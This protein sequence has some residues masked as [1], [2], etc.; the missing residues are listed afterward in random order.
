LASSAGAEVF[1]ALCGSTGS[2]LEAVVHANQ[3]KANK[4]AFRMATLHESRAGLD[5]T[6]RSAAIG[7]TLDDAW[8][9]GKSD[10]RG[11]TWEP[12]AAIQRE[13]AKGRSREFRDSLSFTN[14]R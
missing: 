2:S 6:R 1:A 8:D 4:L 11:P 10:S 3:I 13:A 5:A 9:C 7:G 14:S 12:L